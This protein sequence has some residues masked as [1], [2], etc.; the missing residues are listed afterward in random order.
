MERYPRLVVVGAL[1]VSLAVGCGSAS[2]TTGSKRHAGKSPI[3]VAHPDVQTTGIPR[4][5]L[6]RLRREGALLLSPSRVAFMTTGSVTCAWLPAR[7]AV[8]GR[9]SIRIDMRVNGRVSTCG[10]GAAAFPIAVKIDP[11]TIDVNRPVTVRLAY[12]VRQPGGGG[13]RRWSRTAVAPAISS[14]SRVNPD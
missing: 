10:S 8:L 5:A 9:S 1:T 11:R 13:V 7:L 6:R 4:V 3:V 12:K 14:R 2:H